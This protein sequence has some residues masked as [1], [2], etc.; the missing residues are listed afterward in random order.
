MFSRPDC[1][2][3]K[4]LTGPLKEELEQALAMAEKFTQE[5]NKQLRRFEEQMSNTSSLL[6]L[7][8]KQFGWVSALANNTNNKDGIFKI[9]TV[10]LH[11]LQCVVSHFFV[12]WSYE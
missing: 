3:K 7:F 8:S 9:E 5:Y 11:S 6:D 12:T 10:R 4:P 2:G 1:S